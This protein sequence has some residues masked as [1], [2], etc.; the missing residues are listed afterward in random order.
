MQSLIE[1]EVDVESLFRKSAILA[2]IWE[3]E[4]EKFEMV[5]EVMVK[6]FGF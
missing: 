4:E 3:E 5:E 1:V 6:F 2:I